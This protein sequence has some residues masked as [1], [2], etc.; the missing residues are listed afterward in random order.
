MAGQVK[1]KSHVDGFL[2][3]SRV[4]CIMNSYIRANSES[5]VLSRS[6]EMSKRKCQEKKTL[7]LEKQ[8]LVPPS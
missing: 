1:R 7:V 2:L 8:L 5:L 3:T 4:L 6:A